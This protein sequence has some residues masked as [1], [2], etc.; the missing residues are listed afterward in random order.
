VEAVLDEMETE[1][2]DRVICDIEDVSLCEISA[3][4]IAET[5]FELV[6]QLHWLRG[7]AVVNDGDKEHAQST[8][9]THK[10]PVFQSVLPLGIVSKESSGKACFSN[11]WINNAVYCF[12]IVKAA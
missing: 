9:H 7:D 12:Q 10:L 11:R 3:K 6:P 8:S 1:V 4:I 5:V 2:K